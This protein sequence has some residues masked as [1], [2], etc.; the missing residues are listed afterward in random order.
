MAST[1]SAQVVKAV[2]SSL[3]IDWLKPFQR[4]M[5]SQLSVASSAGPKSMFHKPVV[6]SIHT[7]IRDESAA[8][9]S[10]PVVLSE[11]VLEV[12]LAFPSTSY[13]R[14]QRSIETAASGS[15]LQAPQQLTLAPPP[16]N[17]A[18]KSVTISAAGASSSAAASPRNLISRTSSLSSGQ[19]KKPSFDL[20]ESAAQG[21]AILVNSVAVGTEVH[22]SDKAAQ[23]DEFVQQYKPLDPEG[24]MATVASSSSFLVDFMDN[25]AGST[26]GAGLADAA[27]EGGRYEG[28]S[29]SGFRPDDMEAVSH[30]SAL[31]C[32]RSEPNLNHSRRSM[33]PMCCSEASE[34][35][36]SEVHVT[37]G[38]RASWFS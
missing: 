33:W 18:P 7:L 13:L 36:R 20:P 14:P 15:L 3:E 5:D 28:R 35:F 12:P 19:A 16:H 2:I 10:K 9:V 6:L 4:T 32:S 31:F 37:Q 29:R 21:P 26:G 1:A 38:S 11:P 25:N 22:T 27:E 34:E 8:G 30:A 24:S 23:T 17:E